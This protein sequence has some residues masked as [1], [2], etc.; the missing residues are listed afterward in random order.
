MCEQGIQVGTEYA[1]LRGSSAQGQCRGGEVTHSHHLGSA[2]QE[3]QD[4]VAKGGVKTLDL[5]LG[6]E[7]S[8]QNCVEC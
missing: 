4:P 6:D 1:A 7:L 8:R 3:V 5:E 2:C